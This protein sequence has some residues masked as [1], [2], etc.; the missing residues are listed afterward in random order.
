MGP[1][2]R[3][4]RKTATLLAAAAALAAQHAQAVTLSSPWF[5]S[6]KPSYPL[7]SF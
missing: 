3:N 2:F 1:H 4:S 5:Y 6:L 7:E